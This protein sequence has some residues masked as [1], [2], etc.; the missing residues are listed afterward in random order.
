[1]R[2][3]Q[4]TAPQET[5]VKKP[6]IRR[7]GFLE[8]KNVDRAVE[9]ALYYGFSPVPL[10]LIV[11]KEDKEKART[12]AEAEQRVKDAA[13]FWP[14]IEEKAALF[15]YY[16]DKRLSEGAQP[17]LLASEIAETPKKG[18]EKFLHLDILGSGKS[19]AE[20]V[21]IQ[22]AYAILSEEGFGSLCIRVNSVG[23]RESGN[24]FVREL[25]NY[26]RRSMGSLGASCRSALK[27]N[28]ILLLSCPHEKCRA[29]AAD[30]PKSIAFLSE[31]SRAQFK[32]VLEYLEELEL[33]YRV[34]HELTGCR[35]FGT[36]T[37]FSIHQAG[38]GETPCLA[39]GL[40]YNN[41]GKRLG[42]KRDVPSVGVMIKLLRRSKDKNTRVRI[43]R[44]SIFFLQLGFE[45]K[46][47]SLRVIETL[48]RAG[49]PLYQALARDKLVSQLASAE[50]LRI[51]YSMIMGQREAL[52]NSV[53]VRDTITRA[54]ETVKI[55]DLAAYLKKMKIN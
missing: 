36:E 1:M 12:L 50:N 34:D 51:P 15:R 39:A 38:D 19:I 27:R 13:C 26:F 42:T 25:G 4:P 33:P 55:A 41:L 24:R 14:L 54:Q 46:L 21:L 37:V 2:T 31:S 9:I 6:I 44:P 49:I 17:V 45:A 3:A 11:S 29:L 7:S 22:T 23:D 30:A 28:P 32:E 18:E 10:P 20:A 43:K 16:L 53:I 48:R 8:F 5:A 52:E 40:R 35:S 47:K